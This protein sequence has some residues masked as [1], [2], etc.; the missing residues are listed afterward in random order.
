MDVHL[1]W[2]GVSTFRL[3]LGGT[4]VWLDAYMDRV[5]SAPPVGLSSGEVDRADYI[6]VGHSHF[7]HLYGAATIAKNTGATIVGSYETVRLMSDAGI[8]EASLLPVSGGEPLDLGDNIRVRVFPSL[9]SCIWAS[10]GRAA[11]DECLGDLGVSHQERVGRLSAGLA[12]GGGTEEIRAHLETTGPWP[13][14]DGGAL[15]YLIETPE[16]SI[17]WK[18]T[19]GHWT[20]LLPTLRPDV[21][22]LAAAGRGNVDGEPVQGSLSDFIAQEVRHLEPG[23]VLLCHHDNWM[24]PFTQELDVD[25]I[26]AALKTSAPRTDL[27]EVGYLDPYPVLPLASRGGRRPGA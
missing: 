26:R 4:V 21:A 6:L 7:D 9:H 3:T 23:R 24:P 17:L 16:G 8:G 2:L 5:P 14:G 19:S 18:D 13:R 27:V 10:S 20:S 11:D 15:A 12:A 22:L 25:P 1:E